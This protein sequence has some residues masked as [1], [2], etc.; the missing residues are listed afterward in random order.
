MRG[1][2]EHDSEELD[3]SLAS[4]FSST[5][6]RATLLAMDRIDIPPIE[7]AQVNLLC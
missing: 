5:I 7:K 6:A 1:E 2:D 4:V 3:A